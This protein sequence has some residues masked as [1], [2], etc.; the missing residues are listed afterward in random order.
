MQHRKVHLFD[1]D[2]KGGQRFKESDTLSAGDSMT[3]FVAKVSDSVLKIGLICYDIRFPEMLQ[4]MRQDGCQMLVF[5]AAFNTTTG[6][7]IGSCF[8]VLSC[9]SQCFVVAATPLVILTVDI[10]PGVTSV[11]DPWVRSLRVVMR[12]RSVLVQ[13]LLILI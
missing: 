2:V 9:R 6:P 8:F 4:L 5:P 3:S 13:Y 7:R 11:I 1:I 10:K 12:F